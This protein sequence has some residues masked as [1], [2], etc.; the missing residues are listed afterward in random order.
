MWL[1]EDDASL[2]MLYQKEFESMGHDV[3]AFEDGRSAF[4]SLDA[5]GPDLIIMDVRMPKGDGLEFL[6]RLLSEHFSV[7]LIIHS[8]YEH[9]RTHFMC[10]AAD[11]FVMKSSDLS[12]LKKTIQALLTKHRPV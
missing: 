3:V 6:S 10:W 12:E 2:R 1:L 11:V 4:Q 9:Y 5:N 8:G 7:P